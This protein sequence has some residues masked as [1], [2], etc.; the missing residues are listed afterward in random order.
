M[1]LHLTKK[2]VIGSVIAIVSVLSTGTG[3]W[4]Y[5]AP[6]SYVSLD[7]NPSIEY[8]LNR[9]ERVI[10]VKAVN[11]DGQ[12]VLDKIDISDLTNKSIEDAIMNTVEQISEDGYFEGDTTEAVTVTDNSTTESSQT[13]DTTVD[14]TTDSVKAI[15][16]G[17]VITIA[18][19][20]SEIS[21]QMV[22][23]L[24]LAV[25]DFVS[26]NVEVEVTSVGYE[27][28]QEARALGVTPG[29][30]N[31]VEKLKAS[32]D[33]P[34]S[35]VL[36]EWLNKP[37]K[38]IMKAIK[39]NSKEIA[40]NTND[41][42][43][44]DLEETSEIS[45]DSTIEA[46]ES[47]DDEDS[48]A[49]EEKDSD[50]FEEK[51]VDKKKTDKAISTKLKA[52]VKQA[53]KEHKN[54]EHKNK[55]HNYKSK[56]DKTLEDKTQEDSNVELNDMEDTDN[57]DIETQDMEDSQEKSTDKEKSNVKIQQDDSE[58]HDMEKVDNEDSSSHYS[59]SHSDSSEGDSHRNSNISEK[60]GN[61]D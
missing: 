27:R 56:E 61:R 21:E 9:F 41:G 42:N 33:N 7:V 40:E 37:V 45:E 54:K 26:D 31:L 17:I 58:E 12:I 49:F 4:A 50:A 25:K 18:N 38:D 19:P 35:I 2:L 22:N 14:E 3:V 30:L 15:D 13:T 51:D 32:S 60:D 28:V 53:N 34:D 43:V 10:D 20:N 1:K 44:N 47:V 48:D 29:K 24:Q 16:G 36:D 23:D 52:E 46:S 6:Y 55:E 57:T 8:T 39:V 59:E 5:T 11:D